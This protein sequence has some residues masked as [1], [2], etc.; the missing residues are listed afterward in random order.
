MHLQYIYSITGGITMEFRGKLFGRIRVEGMYPQIK[1]YTVS[2]INV[3]KVTVSGYNL[4]EGVYI[5]L[6]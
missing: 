4:F 1:A 5:R 2:C 3:K 6:T